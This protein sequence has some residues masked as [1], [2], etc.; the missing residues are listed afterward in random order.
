MPT[1]VPPSRR[2]HSKLRDDLVDNWI[3]KV[4]EVRAGDEQHVYLR[5]YWL[6]RPED[7]PAGRKWY[8]G[9]NEVIPSNYMQI[10]DAM[11]VNNKI[12]IVEW[13]ET[14]DED[15]IELDKLFWRQTWNAQKKSLSVR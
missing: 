13:N 7:L 10:I 5:V 14:N 12:D 6:F 15:N 9:E 1:E 3:G 2:P 4:L 11:S 8:H